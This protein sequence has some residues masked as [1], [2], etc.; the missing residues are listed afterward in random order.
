MK[1]IKSIY[2]SQDRTSKQDLWKYAPI[3][4]AL[5]HSD[6]D[7]DTLSTE[8]LAGVQ[9]LMTMIADAVFTKVF[10]EPAT[11]PNVKLNMVDWVEGSEDYGD[12][13]A[14][15]ADGETTSVDAE[16]GVDFLVSVEGTGNAEYDAL[17]TDEKYI[18]IGVYFDVNIGIDYRRDD[19]EQGECSATLVSCM[20]EGI[21]DIELT[22]NVK[23]AME[24]AF[25]DPMSR[26]SMLYR[27]K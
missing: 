24:E 13:I 27:G 20:V 21:W 18:T 9:A 14:D 1:Y 5:T 7:Q 25:E 16:V 15:N 6:L 8:E 3:M 22:P 19:W 12:L 10:I 4:V 2:E 23:A 26:K 17:F 11:Y